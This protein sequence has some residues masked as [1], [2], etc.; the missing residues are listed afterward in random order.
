MTG[1]NPYTVA[2]LAAACIIITSAAM[3][4]IAAAID[5]KPRS[6]PTSLLVAVAYAAGMVT[7]LLIIGLRTS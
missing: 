2:A 3:G 4:L 5:G 6:I 7:A 1:M